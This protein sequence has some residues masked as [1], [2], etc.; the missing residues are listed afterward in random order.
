MDVGEFTRSATTSGLG[1]NG[2]MGVSRVGNSGTGET[3]SSFKGS[4]G[5]FNV[6][7]REINVASSFLGVIVSLSIVKPGAELGLGG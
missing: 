2:A 4:S 7:G 5:G 6:I 3:D 1:G